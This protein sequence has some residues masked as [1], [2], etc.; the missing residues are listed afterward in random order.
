MR[1]QGFEPEAS[2]VVNIEAETEVS[3]YI[4]DP[5]SVQV[6]KMYLI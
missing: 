1:A 4:Y 3:I 6:S 2:Q 5:Q